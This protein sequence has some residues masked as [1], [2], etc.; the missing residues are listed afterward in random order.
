MSSAAYME[1]VIIGFRTIQDQK[2][3]RN[4]ILN[5]YE[6]PKLS[7]ILVNNGLLF[8][9]AGEAEYA[10]CAGVGVSKRLPRALHDRIAQGYRRNPVA[11]AKMD[12]DALLA[13][14]GYAVGIL[15]IA[16]QLRGRDRC[17][18]PLAKR[19]QQ[20]PSGGLELLPRT[21][22]RENLAVVL[23]LIHI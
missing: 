4:H 22:V 12:G 15:R 3:G 2:V 11:P 7:P 21:A 13:L 20:I 17:H 23:S 14:F 8:L 18:G 10:A 1:D 19:T 16:H 5:I 6:I 9:V